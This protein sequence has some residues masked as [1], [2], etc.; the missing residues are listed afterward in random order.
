MAAMHTSAP[1]FSRPYIRIAV[2]LDALLTPEGKKG[3]ALPWLAGI[4]RAARQV[5]ANAPG[6]SPLRISCISHAGSIAR[7]QTA[8]QVAQAEGVHIER[9]HHGQFKVLQAL[10]EAPQLYLK[11]PTL[12]GQP[13]RACHGQVVGEVIGSAIRPFPADLLAADATDVCTC[14]FDFDGVLADDS[15]ERLF[16]SLGLEAYLKHETERAAEPMPAGPL[17]GLALGLQRLRDDLAV[18]ATSSAAASGAELGAALG[19][20]TA[21]DRRLTPFRLQLGLLTARGAE[22]IPRVLSSLQAWQFFPCR[23]DCQAGAQKA[24]I[25]R[26]LAADVFFDDG[27]HN[28]Q[29]LPPFT[30][31]VHMPVAAAAAVAADRI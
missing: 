7:M 13:Q 17:L 10:P 3:P 9:L 15:S 22:A 23:I 21:D 26:L 12:T 31:A 18:A 24:P 4:T 14:L 16:Q 27:L 11:L 20:P 8:L 6:P 29:D 5:Q 2:D 1:A 19:L 30:L 25:V 28:F